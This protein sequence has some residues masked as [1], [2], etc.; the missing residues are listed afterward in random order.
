MKEI[1]FLRTRHSR[2]DSTTLTFVDIS[3]PDYDASQHADVDYKTAMGSMHAVLSDGSVVTGVPVFR[4]AYEA[5][6]LGWV[7]AMTKLPIVGWLADR[8]YDLWAR[9]RLRMTGRPDLETI[10]EMRRERVEKG[11]K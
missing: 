3:S 10:M 11:C 4:L 8:V 1:N 9:W 7:Y 6:G 5:V 2:L